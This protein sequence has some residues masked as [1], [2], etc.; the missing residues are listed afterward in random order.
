MSRNK[1]ITIYDIAKEAGVSVATVSR[2]YN[3]SANVSE[4]KRE[5]IKRIL[6]KYNYVP[7]AF[8][9]GLRE[10]QTQTLGIIAADLRNPFFSQLLVECEKIAAMSG[11][12]VFSCDSLESDEM[13]LGHFMRLNG[14]KVDAIINMGGNSEKARRSE[15]YL[16]CLKEV[17]SRIPVVTTGYVD[18]ENMYSVMTDEARAMR[19]LL[20]YLINMG[21]R[22]IAFIG[23]RADVRSTLIKREQFIATLQKKGLF[24]ASSYIIEGGYDK[25]S[26]Y[27]S[28]REL[29][30]KNHMPS[31]VIAVNELTALGAMKALRE[32]KIN[33]P[34]ELS[35]ACFDN[36]FISETTQPALTTLGCDYSKFSKKLI[37]TALD[38]IEGR[39]PP[40]IS[41]VE[42]AFVIRQSVAER[43]M[44]QMYET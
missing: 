13:E 19:T 5:E 44:G 42:S 10:T 27:Q 37:Y 16:N 21:H 29:L 35:L 7:D 25:E 4:K 23:G 12:T 14:Q 43:Q 28:M 40:G 39:T 22:E 31:A 8:A 30:M 15:P 24:C 38:A 1:R 6:K 36:T 2:V 20:E 3:E 26:G 34:N 18:H 41:Y 11:Y 33:I 9:K 32:R 17:C